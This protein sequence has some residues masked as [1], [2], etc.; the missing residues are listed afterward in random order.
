MRQHD[1]E[2]ADAID[3]AA[4]STQR[5]VAASEARRLAEQAGVPGEP[6]IAE[7]LARNDPEAR[8]RLPEAVA[9]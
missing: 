3:A 4:P 9:V 5:A 7:A 6:E 2:L 1:P 8:G